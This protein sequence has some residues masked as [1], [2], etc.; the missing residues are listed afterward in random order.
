MPF[1]ISPAP[2]EFQRRMDI[3]LEGLPGIKTIA[4]DILL[5]G[6][7]TT[8]E[9]AIKDH[10]TKLRNLLNRC[11]NKSLK[12]NESKLQLR[13][14]R[15]AF[16]GHLITADGL[17]PDP[18]KVSAIVD[19]P[20]PIDKQAVQRFLGM[21]NYVQKFAPHLSE[22]TKPLRDL[23]KND[24]EFTW[25]EHVHGKAFTEAKKILSNTPILQ[26]FNPTVQPVLQCDASQ[27]GLGA[28]L[29]QNG[30]P[31][32]YASRSLTHTETNYAQI[33]KEMLAIVYGMEKFNTYVYGRKT[34]VESDHKPLEAIFK[35][36]LTSAPKRLQR[37]MLRLQQFEFE[38]AYKRGT[39][40]YMADTLSRAYLRHNKVPST[41]QEQVM[42]VTQD[43]RFPTEKEVEHINMCQF[44][45]VT[46]ETLA[47]IQAHTRQDQQLQILTQV[48]L[49]GWP[50]SIKKVKEDVH[51]Y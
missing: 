32:A 34:L 45:P 41:D 3:T 22:V 30:H 25:D 39:Q 11:R 47:K 46:D 40:M 42:T 44:L 26:Y 24:T 7:G 17:R 35:K 21:V 50:D 27:N 8:D 49:Q 19:M 18:D 14:D 20:S 4:D 33:E 38:V 6:A 37:M 12:L 10:D 36:G 43:D 28:C 31:I 5:F 1:G 51:D 13:K 16:M 29:M 15:V 23:V 48:I 9:E 2:V